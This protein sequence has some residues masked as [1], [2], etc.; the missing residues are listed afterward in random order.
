MPNTRHRKKSLRRSQ[1]ANDANRA[2]RSSMR[3]AV[4]RA[5]QAAESDPAG[6]DAALTAAARKLDKAARQNLIH[7]NKAARIK[8]RLAKARNRAQAARG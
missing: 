6:A 7:K 1:E 8:S 4:K 5:R 2:Q 3:T